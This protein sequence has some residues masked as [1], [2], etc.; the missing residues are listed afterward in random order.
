MI[1]QK[2]PYSPPPPIAK[3]GEERVGLIGFLIL[4]PLPLPCF[5]DAADTVN[6]TLVVISARKEK[7]KTCLRMERE[8]EEERAEKETTIFS[9]HRQKEVRTVQCIRPD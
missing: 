6:I 1:R 8:R 4:P 2:P 7:E 9:G 5:E 3:A